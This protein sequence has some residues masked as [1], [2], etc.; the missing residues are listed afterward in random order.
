[1]CDNSDI[2]DN[3]RKVNKRRKTPAYE[4]EKCPYQVKKGHNNEIKYISVPNRK[5]IFKWKH[6]EK[7]NT[8]CSKSGGC[9]KTN[10]SKKW[11]D[12]DK[13]DKNNGICLHTEETCKANDKVYHEGKCISE[14]RKKK[15]SPKEYMTVSSKLKN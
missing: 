6:Y 7:Y 9:D 2:I 5:G 14:K 11:C 12:R 10:S 13:L 4:P 8:S 15:L 1:M 3:K